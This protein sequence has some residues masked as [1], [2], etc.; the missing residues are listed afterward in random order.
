MQWKPREDPTEKSLEEKMDP[1][2]WILLRGWFR[3]V[4]YKRNCAEYSAD[5][6]DDKK[7]PCPQ[8]ANKPVEEMDT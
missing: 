5:H 8:R 3:D 1:Q 2:C 6:R 4:L 7:G